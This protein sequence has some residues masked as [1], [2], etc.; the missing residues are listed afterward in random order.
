MVAALKGYKLVC[1]AADK[2]P[3]EKIALLEAFGA[4]VAVGTHPHFPGPIRVH[5]GLGHH[6]G[7]DPSHVQ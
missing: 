3:A 6:Q 2:I 7:G 5:G 1:T 4:Q